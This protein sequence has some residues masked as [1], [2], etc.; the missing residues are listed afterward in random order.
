MIG[1]KEKSRQISRE[2]LNA[3]RLY[4]D[5]YLEQDAYACNM[6]RSAPPKPGKRLHRALESEGAA[7]T[8]AQAMPAE[9]PAPCESAPKEAPQMAAT[10]ANERESEEMPQ[11]YFSAALADTSGEDALEAYLREVKD[12]SFSEMLL[13]KIDEKGMSDADCYKKANI[14]KRLFSKIRSNALYKPSKQ[15]ALALILA[16]ELPYSEAVEMLHKAGFALSRASKADL[17]VEYYLKQGIYDIFVINNSLYDFD[18]PII[19]YK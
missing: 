8:C 6:Q 17:I 15:T 10:Q 2:H 9:S 19:G 13:R 14:D 7:P 16:L 3:I 5:T 1:H 18:Q 12:E 11:V 4:I